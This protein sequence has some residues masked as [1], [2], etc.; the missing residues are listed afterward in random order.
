MNIA[1]FASAAVVAG[2]VA[3]RFATRKAT[4]QFEAME[5]AFVAN[6]NNTHIVLVRGWNRAEL[7]EILDDFLA[8]YELPEW[9]AQADERPDDVL[10]VTFP[11]D[12]QP[13]LLYFLVNYIQYP[14]DF[15]LEGRSIG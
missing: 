15:E 2:V 12:I 11:Q 5:D 7:D 1:L 14:K 4:K 8:S 9:T 6:P 10:A 3:L 13:H